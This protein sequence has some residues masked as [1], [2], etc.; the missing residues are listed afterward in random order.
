MKQACEHT[1]FFAVAQ[2]G[3]P[4]AAL[5]AT[6]AAARP[7][8]DLPK[9]DKERLVVRGMRAGRGYE[10]SPEHLAYEA[11]VRE[12][13]ASSPALDA[14]LRDH[15]E[16]SVREALMSERFMCGP[17]QPPGADVA[18]DGDL[19]VTA[20][21]DE[22]FNEVRSLPKAL[23]GRHKERPGLGGHT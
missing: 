7:L 10:V 5:T 14:A 21:E 22:D 4:T 9:R 20:E 12:V 1:G 15:P 2:H 17:R 8:F 13:R 19:G 6:F 3:C 18:P 11:H 23:S 16:P